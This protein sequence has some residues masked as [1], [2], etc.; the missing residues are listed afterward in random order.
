M[1]QTKVKLIFQS[2]PSLASSSPSSSASTAGSVK[3]TFP[4][5]A[6]ITSSASASPSSATITGAPVIKK[7]ESSSGLT[8]KLMHP[9]EDISLVSILEHGLSHYFIDGL[10]E[11]CIQ[12]KDVFK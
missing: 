7:P 9:D 6:A 5:A 3:P 8:S 12:G 1:I 11:Y 4:S 10:R 2:S